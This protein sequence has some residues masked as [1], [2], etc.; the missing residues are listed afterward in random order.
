VTSREPE[1]GSDLIVD[2][3]VDL[4]VEI[5]PFAPGAT[6]RG[7]H[8]SLVNHRDDAPEIIE[9]LHEEI[10]V[11]VA[12][13]YAKASGSMPAVAL[14]DVVGLQHASMALY[15]AWC[16]RVPLLALGGTGPVDAAKRRPWIDWI[17]TANVQATQVRDYTKWDDQPASLEAVPESLVRARQLATSVPQGPVYIC[18]DSEIQEQALTDST[19]A[20]CAQAFPAARPLHPEPAAVA[21]MAARLVGARMPLIA[22]ESVQRSQATLESLCVLS[23]L[24]GAPVVEVQR[25]YNRTELCIPTRHPHNLT[26]M[27]LPED[28]D[29]VLALEVRDVA[30]IPGAGSAPVLHVSTAGLGVKAWAADLQRVQPAEL[31]LAAEVGPTVQ[32]L[33]PAVREEL[34]SDPAAAEAAKERARRLA[35]VTARQW[36]SW[37]QSAA[38][39]P[40]DGSIPPAYL[41]RALDRV[42]GEHEPVLANGS[43]H[44]WVHRLWSID[45]VDRYLG[46]S[47]GAGLGYGLGASVGAALAHRGSGRLVVDIQSD[48]DALMTPSAFWTAA[49]HRAPLLIVMENNRQWGNS[50]MHAR[51]IAEARGRSQDRA[52]IG[53]MI[54]EPVVDFVRLAESMGVTDAWRVETSVDLESTVRRAMDIVRTHARPALVEVVTAS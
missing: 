21:H 20:L 41:A 6:F 49:R 53:T 22:V 51:R 9:C 36:A 5:I 27:A 2:M 45:R 17:H 50:V 7:L 34:E 19:P 54:R 37:E 46:S 23:E 29:V 3:L 1:Y 18:I 31:L 38:R 28:P 33:I 52:G 10:S 43:L 14:H 44:N 13:G 4:G 39:L 24:L 47:G 16:D 26:G 8:D 15:N 30:V 11:A 42:V 40:D 12:H 35:G 32:A 25:D 48:G